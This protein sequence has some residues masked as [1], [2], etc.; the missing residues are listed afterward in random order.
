MV[1]L[2]EWDANLLHQ[3]ARYFFLHTKTQH[4]I[5]L[6]RKFLQA[7]APQSSN[8]IVALSL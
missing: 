8:L 3:V 2:N 6:S 5:G 1:Y 4:F 7:K